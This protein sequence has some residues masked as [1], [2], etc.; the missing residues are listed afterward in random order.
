MRKLIVS[1]L[2]LGALCGSALAVDP[3]WLDSVETTASDV[4][5]YAGTA[6]VAGLAIFAVLFGVRVVLRAVRAG[7]R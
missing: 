4:A 1:L 7:A 6:I 5:G 3:A 2:A